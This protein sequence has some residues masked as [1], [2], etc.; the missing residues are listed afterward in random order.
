VHFNG[1]LWQLLARWKGRSCCRKNEIHALVSLTSQ[2]QTLL[3]SFYD[4]V[5]SSEATKVK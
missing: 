4:S 5:I 3:E 1:S 2:T